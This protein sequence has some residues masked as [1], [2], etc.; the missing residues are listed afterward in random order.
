MRT[1][2]RGFVHRPARSVPATILAVV[3]LG[4]GG[5]GAWVLGSRLVTQ[6]W[7]DQVSG[8]MQAAAETRMDAAVPVAIAIILIAVGLVAVL[9]ALVPGDA[10]H[11]AAMADDVPGQ[12][13]IA[14]HDLAR[15]VKS[16]VQ[17]ID[18]VQGVRSSLRRSRLTV[19]VRS[20]VDDTSTV[21]RDAQAAVQESL[22]DLRLVRAVRPRVRVTR[23]R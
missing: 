17:R 12:T 5:L 15:Q 6:E 3:G 13:A 2:P 21:K 19:E 10:A 22:Q 9:V 14:R 18:G 1:T 4:V 20:P 7:P 11:R 23:T 8:F 16:R